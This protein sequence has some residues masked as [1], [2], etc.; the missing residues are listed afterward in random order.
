M[1]AAI[2]RRNTLTDPSQGSWP[3]QTP[4]SEGQ[5][6]QQPAYGAPQPQYGAPQPGYGAPAYGAPAPGYGAPQQQGGNG[7]AV[8]ALILGIL[9]T[10]LIG[11]VVGILAIIK[12]GKTGAGKAMAWIGTILSVLWMVAGIAIIV[13]AGSDVASTVSKRIDPGCVSIESQTALANKMQGET[14]PAEMQKDIQQLID[15][16]KADQAK[17]KSAAV[18]TALANFQKDF[19][20][21]QGALKGGTM[22]PDLVSRLTTDGA[23][24]DTACGH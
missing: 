24:V 13:A 7:L 5:V 22:P 10:G 21:L 3:Q 23:A 20:D 11:L 4:P 19:E 17:T 16:L 2:S 12:A 9:P 1:G 8:A 18:R 6:P 15:E 14:D